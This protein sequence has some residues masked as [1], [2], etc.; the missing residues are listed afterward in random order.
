MPELIPV[1]YIGR[2]PEFEY[3]NHAKILFAKD[4]TKLIPF[5]LSERLLSHPDLFEL[6]VLPTKPAD[7]KKIDTVEV[8]DKES[9][10]YEK[11]TAEREL[12]M[13]MTEYDLVGYAGTFNLKQGKKESIEDLRSR[14][15]IEIDTVGV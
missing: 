3:A 12:V 6:G 5:E 10:D 1:K 8:E 9:Y 7:I 2:F 15:L 4:E 13:A 11:N 14:V